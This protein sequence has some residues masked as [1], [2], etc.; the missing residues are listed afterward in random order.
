MVGGVL[1]IRHNIEPLNAVVFA[2]GKQGVPAHFAVLLPDGHEM[3][4][5]QLCRAFYAWIYQRVNTKLIA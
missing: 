1:V 5:E 3:D 4:T 2:G